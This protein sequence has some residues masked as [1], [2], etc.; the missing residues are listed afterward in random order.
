MRAVWVDRGEL[1]V[2]CECMCM[3]HAYVTCLGKRSAAGS[4][5]YC[6]APSQAGRHSRH[7]MLDSQLQLRS[8][9]ITLPM[10]TTEQ[11]N[12]KSI[13]NKS[14]CVPLLLSVSCLQHS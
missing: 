7:N 10:K 13:G 12:P 2:A 6:K 14:M 9:S 5:L 11:Y 4:S 8:D 3:D 1:V